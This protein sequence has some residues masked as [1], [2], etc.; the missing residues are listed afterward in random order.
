MNVATLDVRKEGDFG[1]LEWVR[2]GELDPN[3][4]LHVIVAVVWNVTDDSA[5]TE[6]VVVFGLSHPQARRLLVARCEL[7]RN[8]L[9]CRHLGYALTEVEAL[10]FTQVLGTWS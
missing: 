7:L 10:N 3:L 2:V 8:T 1:S 5:P 9:Y 6:H 4:V